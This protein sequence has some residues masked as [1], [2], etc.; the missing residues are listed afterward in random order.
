MGLECIMIFQCTDNCGTSSESR[1]C[2]GR[3]RSLLGIDDATKTEG[4]GAV[5]GWCHEEISAVFS[6]AGG[7][8]KEPDRGLGL[9]VPAAAQDGGAGMRV[10]ILVCPLPDVA[11]EVHDAEG[12]S[13]GGDSNME[14]TRGP[15]STARDI[16][17]ASG[18]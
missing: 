1:C 17:T 9:R 3:G 15:V 12:A 4:P 16:R 5:F 14:S 2:M 13:A 8:R 18:S 6:V 7:T 11:A 10:L